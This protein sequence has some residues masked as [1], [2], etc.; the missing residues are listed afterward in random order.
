M[1]T[2]MFY[3]LN[4]IV[5][6]HQINKSLK[7]IFLK[8][9]FLEIPVYKSSALSIPFYNILDLIKILGLLKSC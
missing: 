1:L 2:K 7:N 3:V 6:K 8:M 9:V 4:F 5:L